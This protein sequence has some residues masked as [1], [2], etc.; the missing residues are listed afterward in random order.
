MNFIIYSTADV[1]YTAE[2]P[3]CNATITFEG[4]VSLGITKTANTMKVTHSRL[5]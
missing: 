3:T 4:E 2:I 5:P 1:D